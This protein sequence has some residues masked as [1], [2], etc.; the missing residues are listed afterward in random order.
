MASVSVAWIFVLLAVGVLGFFFM[1][2]VLLAKVMG[3]FFRML[4]FSS[5]K[6]GH[7]G[8]RPPRR[9]TQG[10]ICSAPRCTHI[11][12]RSAGFC[13]RCGQALKSAYDTDV[14]G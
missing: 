7:E 14:Y 13:A 5:N 9:D 12:R 4:G 11:N 10:V 8:D 2:A 6:T 3:A 1:A